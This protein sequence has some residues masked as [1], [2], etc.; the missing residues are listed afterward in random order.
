MIPVQRIPR[1]TPQLYGDR[2]SDPTLPTNGT[3]RKESSQE[4]NSSE[5]ETKSN[6]SRSNTKRRPLGA[7]TRSVTTLSAAQRERNRANDREAQRAIRQRMKDYVESLERRIVELSEKS[8][9]GAE[10]I[11]TMQRNEE[12]EQENAILRSKLSNVVATRGCSEDDGMFA[13]PYH[14]C[15]KSSPSTCCFMLMSSVT[16]AHRQQWWNAHPWNGLT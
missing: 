6:P 8:D 14:S 11:E 9:S 7:G 13:V 16:S 10:L 1:R 2:M 12:L 4:G 5:S 15:V 3:L